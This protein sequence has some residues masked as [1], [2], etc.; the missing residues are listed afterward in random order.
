MFPYGAT[1]NMQYHDL[2]KLTDNEAATATAATTT[3]TT[4][5]ADATAAGKLTELPVGFS[6][7]TVDG[8]EK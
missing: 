5:A 1:D 6:H 4:T 3:T 2:D 8:V 7:T